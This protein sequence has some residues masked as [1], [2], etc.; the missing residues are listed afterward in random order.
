MYNSPFSSLFGE[1]NQP[2]TKNISKPGF[3]TTTDNPSDTLKKEAIL[4]PSP[5]E[6]PS[7]SPSSATTKDLM[8][9]I[10]EKV[11]EAKKEEVYKPD[12]IKKK[13]FSSTLPQF[14]ARIELKSKDPRVQL[15]LI[16]FKDVLDGEKLKAIMQ[17]LQDL[18]L[19]T[20][21]AKI[22]KDILTL[23]IELSTS[24]K[25]SIK[26]W[27]SKNSKLINKLSAIRK[28]QEKIKEMRQARTT[29]ERGSRY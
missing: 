26:D 18:N 22:Y 10:Q 15:E 23:Y 27:I 25:L 14:K 4:P 13:I 3:L 7:V 2:N 16:K 5:S 17:R 8:K 19:K 9:E 20:K 29:K 28:T 6:N 11:E 12:I 24:E 21:S 1:G